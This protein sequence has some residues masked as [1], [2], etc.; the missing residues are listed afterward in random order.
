VI[1]RFVEFIIERNIAFYIANDGQYISVNI[2]ASLEII[3]HTLLKKC[4]SSRS[5]QTR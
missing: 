3:N 1:I 4:W 2:K 5:W